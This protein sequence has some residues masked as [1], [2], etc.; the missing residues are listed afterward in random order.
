M[1]T[2]CAF[3][4][5][6]LSMITRFRKYA[7]ESNHPASAF[8]SHVI[9]GTFSHISKGEVNPERNLSPKPEQQFALVPETMAGQHGSP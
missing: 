6:Y 9:G 5:F 7:S 2:K 4:Q 3:K 1:N 8:E